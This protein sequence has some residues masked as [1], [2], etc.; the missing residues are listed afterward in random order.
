MFLLDVVDLYKIWTVNS[1]WQKKFWTIGESGRGFGLEIMRKS[2]FKKK[3][4]KKQK[5]EN[6]WI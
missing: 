2:K 1:M 3:F 6:Y 4:K 5:N